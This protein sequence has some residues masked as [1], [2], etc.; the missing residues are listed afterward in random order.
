MPPYNF[1]C[2]MTDQHRADHLGCYGNAVLSTPHLDRIAAGGLRFERFYV[3]NPVCMPNRATLMT[4]RL[5]SN[6]G[7]RH[8]GISLHPRSNTFVHL[9]RN[10]GYRTALIG[11]S[12]LQNMGIRPPVLRKVAPAWPVTGSLDTRYAE[13][14]LPDDS[15]RTDIE[16]LARWRDE[17]EVE[18]PRPYYGF[19]EVKLTIGHGDFVRGHYQ[20]WLAER[21][22]A[23]ETLRGPD[24]ALPSALHV[25]QAWRTRVP[26]EL[27]PTTYITEHT[28]QYL[29]Q[30]AASGAHAPFFLL[31]SFPDPHHPFV[32]PGHYFNLYKPDDIPLPPAWGNTHDRTPPHMQVLVK[33]LGTPEAVRNSPAAFAVDATEARQAMALTYGMISMIDDGVGRILD[34]LERLGL[35]DNTVV[36]FTSDHG[37]LMGDH[38]LMLKGPYHFQGLIRVPMLL[39][40]PGMTTG[41][42]T[43]ALACTVD[44]AQTILQLAALEPYHGI[45]GQ[46]L[47][48]LLAA[49]DT[50]VRDAILIEDDGQRTLKGT[51]RPIRLRTLLTSEW[52][53]TYYDGFE[54]G[55]LYNLQDDPIEHHNLWQDPET[56]D[57]K[58]ALREQLLRTIIDQQDRSPL[59][60]YLA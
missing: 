15:V 10:A 4:G 21:H 28:V 13:P 60:A 54:F 29:E 42:V 46:S 25:P 3:A 22:T 44:L 30:H 23:P 24:N 19:D 38:Q 26:E 59:P 11:K 18:I 57:A 35:A 50:T 56:H 36:L 48:P 9:L 5:P 8:N 1:L 2:I 39:K 43:N 20:N 16:L 51:N 17:G 58:T 45:Q 32:P 12:H 52:R 33:E 27:Y 55:E 34:T 47:V 31:C 14:L 37:D 53:F 7:V 41:A 6:H 40:V 49:P